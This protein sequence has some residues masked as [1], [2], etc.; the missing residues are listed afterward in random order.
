M[1]RLVGSEMCIRDSYLSEKGVSA[2]RMTA[3]GFGESM[4][5][6]ANEDPESRAM[7]RRTEFEIVE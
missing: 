4:P 6:V 5:R 7:N 2:E 1:T 3:S